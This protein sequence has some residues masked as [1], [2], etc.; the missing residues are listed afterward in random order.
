M[1]PSIDQYLLPE[2]VE[3]LMK[4]ATD[5]NRPEH[6]IIRGV[7]TLGLSAAGMALGAGAGMGL[8][9]GAEKLLGKKIPM[10]YLVPATAVLGAGA[11][12]AEEAM[13]QKQMEEMKDAIKNYRARPKR[14][15]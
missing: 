5:K 8:G 6:P 12:W 7:K 1:I 4:V 15:R 9:Y 2:V 14:P 11:T 10:K 13:R 3:A